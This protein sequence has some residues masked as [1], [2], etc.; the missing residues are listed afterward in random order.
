MTFFTVL[1][2]CRTP[3]SERKS[4]ATGTRIAVG[5]DERVL[6]HERQRRRAV[7]DDDVVR[8]E[9]R[10]EPVAQDAVAV[11][12]AREVELGGGE[13]LVRDDE[14]EVRPHADRRGL[15]AQRP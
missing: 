9:G 1:M 10:R 3:T 12:A 6:V 15:G 2:T 7:E 8:V 5:D 14:I 13:G 4:H 11:L